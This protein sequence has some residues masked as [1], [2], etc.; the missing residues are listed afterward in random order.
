MQVIK[1]QYLYIF[2]GGRGVLSIEDIYYLPS[3]IN[4]LPLGSLYD[5][6]KFDQNLN[7]NNVSFE[8]SSQKH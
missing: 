2:Q 4:Y 7:L 5:Q 3:L 8:V 1:T 6:Q